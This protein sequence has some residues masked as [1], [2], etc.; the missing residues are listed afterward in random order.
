MRVLRNK[1]IKVGYPFAFINS[2]IDGF[3]QEKEDPLI[4]TSLFE[5]RK[6]VGFQIPFCKRN[7]NEISCIIDKLEAFTNHQVKFRY[8]WKTKKVR[9]L[10][11]SVS[12]RNKCLCCSSHALC[13]G[14][15]RLCSIHNSFASYDGNI[16]RLSR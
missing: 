3:N 16:I 6:E 11:Q 8:F 13:Y 7:G 5:D 12:G 4:L 14:R 10:F 2:V 1:Y 15:M 9:S